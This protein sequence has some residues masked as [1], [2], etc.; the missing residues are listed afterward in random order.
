MP[1]QFD[2]WLTPV[3]SCN[4]LHFCQGFVLPNLV[5]RILDRSVMHC[6]S[7][8]GSTRG[9]IVQ[10]YPVANKFGREDPWPKWSA[11]LGSNVIHGSARIG[12]VR[13][14]QI[15]QECPM[16]TKFRR[17]NPWLKRSKM[18]GS[19]V[20]WGQIGVNRKSN[21][22]EVPYS[23]QRWLMPHWSR[24]CNRCSSLI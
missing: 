5:G 20:I 11:M 7:Q 24:W 15:I 9:Q 22:L 2:P 4:A 1:E 3:D 16:A 6:R 17:K 23:H 19:K 14:G 13:R 18:L 10:A 12:G 21:C 8:L